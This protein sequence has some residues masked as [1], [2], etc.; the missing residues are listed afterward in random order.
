MQMHTYLKGNTPK[1]T[2]GNPNNEEEGLTGDK[3]DL[4][5]R[6]RDPKKERKREML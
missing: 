6:K 5:V 1:K 3:C 2:Y 4:G